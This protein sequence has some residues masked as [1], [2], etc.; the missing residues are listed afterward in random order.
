M[1]LLKFIHHFFILKNKT[2]HKNQP[3]KKCFQDVLTGCVSSIAISLLGSCLKVVSEHGKLKT[4]SHEY[5]KWLEEVLCYL[6][7]STGLS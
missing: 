6:C 7:F 5:A 4:D 2:K 1:Q 3:T